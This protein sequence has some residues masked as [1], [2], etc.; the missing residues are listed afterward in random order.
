[1]SK[2]FYKTPLVMYVIANNEKAIAGVFI[3]T[4]H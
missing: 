4:N 3:G 2:E 1:M